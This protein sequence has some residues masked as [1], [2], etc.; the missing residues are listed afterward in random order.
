MFCF[1]LP[2][3]VFSSTV[4]LVLYLIMSPCVFGPCVPVLVVSSSVLSPAFLCSPLFILVCTSF[5]F[6][7][8]GLLLLLPVWIQ[9]VINL[10]A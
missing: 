6:I 7:A 1:T 8:L 3:F 5:S 4:S 2:V 10:P 9:F